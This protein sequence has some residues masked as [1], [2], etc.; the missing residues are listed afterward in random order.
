M[1]RQARLVVAGLAHLVQWRS[2]AGVAAFQDLAD[3]DALLH[4][5]RRA[6]ELQRIVLHGWAVRSHALELVV[7]PESATQL[8]HVMQSIGRQYVHA[9]NDRHQR[10]G[11][12][13]AGRYRSCAAQEGEHT[14]QI[15][16]WVDAASASTDLT[17]A[18]HRTG[19]G[20]DRWLTDPPEVWALGNTP[21]DRESRYRL[22]LDEPLPA[23]ARVR[24]EAALR[25]GWVLGDEAFRSGLSERQ[26]RAV[27]PRPR[28]R[29]PRPKLPR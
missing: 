20:A 24:I 8:A 12:V 6:V 22:L 4:A 1:A 2:L 15:L 28:G 17:S 19:A 9:Y 11:T 3:R 27:A 18:S 16:R 5:L 7:R 23:A 14:L 29:P 25:G 21:F 10:A 13:W 26:G